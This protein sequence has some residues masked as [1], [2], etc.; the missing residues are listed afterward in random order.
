MSRFLQ[1]LTHPILE[2]AS[3]DLPFKGV[4]LLRDQVD[5]G[6]SFVDTAF[7]FEVNAIN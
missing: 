2:L 7:M 3:I 4:F 6:T 1:F 5:I